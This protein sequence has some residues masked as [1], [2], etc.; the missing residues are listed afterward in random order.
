MSR[1]YFLSVKNR[2]SADASRMIHP[3]GLIC[4]ATSTTDEVSSSKM[5]IARAILLVIGR[6]SI[7]ISINIDQDI[8]NYYAM[9]GGEGVV[10]NV[11]SNT[12]EEEGLW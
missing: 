2:L 12:L 7:A 4:S 11:V 1:A 3:N 8:A 9:R 10:Y 5:L 6:S